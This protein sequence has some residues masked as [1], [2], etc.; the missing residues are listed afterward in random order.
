MI[1][2]AL[3]LKARLRRACA[4]QSPSGRAIRDL[5]RACEAA[6]PNLQ[7]LTAALEAAEAAGVSAPQVML[8]PRRMQRE[9]QEAEAKRNTTP[10]R[11]HPAVARLQA[12]CHNSTPASHTS[13]EDEG[14]SRRDEDVA[15]VVNPMMIHVEQESERK[16]ARE[17]KLQR[18]AERKAE[19]LAR[20][21]SSSAAAAAGMVVVAAK[22]VGEMVELVTVVDAT[23]APSASGV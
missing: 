21:T 6:K 5:K 17:K 14:S 20:S 19:A 8:L 2:I 12:A 4:S 15:V 13:G 11:P 10:A 9:L 16:A 1:P 22:S 3:V 7:Q 23:A 18:K